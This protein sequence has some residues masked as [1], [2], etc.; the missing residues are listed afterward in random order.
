[1]L[2]VQASKCMHHLPPYIMLTYL[3]YTAIYYE[4]GNDTLTSLLC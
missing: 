1:M 3:I 2:K 4:N